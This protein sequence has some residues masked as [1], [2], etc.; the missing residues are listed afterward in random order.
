V[1]FVLGASGWDVIADHTTNIEALLAG[2][3]A[4]AESLEG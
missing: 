4:L 3:N 1:F 2:A